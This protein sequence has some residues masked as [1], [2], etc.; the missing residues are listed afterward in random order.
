ML[1]FVQAVYNGNFI[2]NGYDSIKC[3][4]KCI[5]EFKVRHCINI[6]LLLGFYKESGMTREMIMYNS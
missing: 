4:D 6:M 2:M 1:H 3:T 5:H